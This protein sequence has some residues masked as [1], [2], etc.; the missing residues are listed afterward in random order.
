MFMFRASQRL[1][2][3]AARS[4]G[5]LNAFQT[6][7]LLG[8]IAL[9]SENAAIA[10]SR[11]HKHAGQSSVRHASV[12]AASMQSGSQTASTQPSASSWHGF[13]VVQIIGLAVGA[14]CLYLLCLHGHRLIRGAPKWFAKHGE[15]LAD[16]AVSLLGAQVISYL[17]CHPSLHHWLPAV[18]AIGLGLGCAAG[19]RSVRKSGWLPRKR[20]IELLWALPATPIL[21]VP[22]LVRNMLKSV[23]FA[24]LV[25]IFIQLAL[26]TYFFAHPSWRQ[27]LLFMA[28]AGVFGGGVVRAY[29]M[30]FEFLQGKERNSFWRSV[31][32]A[33]CSQALWPLAAATMVLYPCATG[34]IGSLVW[35]LH[36]LV[37]VIFSAI[38][39]AL[40]DS[41]WIAAI[42]VLLVIGG[43][44]PLW[45]SLFSLTAR[46]ILPSG[47]SGVD[48]SSASFSWSSGTSDATFGGVDFNSANTFDGGM[49][50]GNGFAFNV[51]GL[52]MIGG[53]GGI[54]VHGN[55]FGTTFN[56][57]F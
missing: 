8:S 19:L 32:A 51:N 40:F 9:L 18:L 36:V 30:T 13:G 43:L 27:G 44:F 56:D 49:F 12:V 15:T 14:F 26:I 21:V 50:G 34:L 35:L 42:P 48:F 28:V 46:L 11:H 55:P 10:A 52:P 39:S 7:S 1:T 37:P 54:D 45:L 41:V 16:Y 4:S 6:A 31:I 24:G 29:C 38:L 22:V 20:Y 23:H 57:P 53:M 33:V 5:R 25:A 47:Y 17:V 2:L 3:F